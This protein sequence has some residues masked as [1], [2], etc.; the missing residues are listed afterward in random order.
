ME[1]HFWL[2]FSDR[3]SRHDNL[4]QGTG[5][6]EIRAEGFQLNSEDKAPL[7]D[8]T[9]AG[10]GNITNRSETN[11]KHSDRKTVD[12]SG[13]NKNLEV[14][15]QNQFGMEGQPG[16]GDKTIR[17]D[18]ETEDGKKQE[19]FLDDRGNKFNDC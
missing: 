8:R 19:I 3:F 2:Y 9:A 5:P 12:K 4:A 6:L 11:V 15:G 17:L 14:V 13:N 7:S 18:L 16:S 1:E 10:D